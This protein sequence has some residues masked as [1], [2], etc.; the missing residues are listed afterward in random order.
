EIG[1]EKRGSRDHL[2]VAD[3][4]GGGAEVEQQEQCGKDERRAPTPGAAS[5]LQLGTA[6]SSHD[7]PPLNLEKVGTATDV[8]R[9][10]ITAWKKSHGEGGPW[11]PA[12]TGAADGGAARGGERRRGE[13]RRTKRGTGAV[14]GDAGPGCAVRRA[15]RAC[16]RGSVPE[17]ARAGQQHRHAVL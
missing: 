16:P 14:R 10:A 13:V 15:R 5:A 11:R 1:Q 3:V 17:V 6:V 12:R 9:N 7:R 2:R 4:G 8:W